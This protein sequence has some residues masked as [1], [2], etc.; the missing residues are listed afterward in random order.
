MASDLLQQLG[1]FEPPEAMRALPRLEALGI[2]FEIEIEP[3]LLARTSGALQAYLGIDAEA[4]K[5]AVFVPASRL[6][7]ATAA[8][9]AWLPPGPASEW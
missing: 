7:E 4:S 3:G 5:L 8:V 1:T 2:P 9:Q 6:A